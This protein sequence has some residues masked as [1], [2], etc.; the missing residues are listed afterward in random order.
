[1][2]SVNN[3]Y[4]ISLKQSAIEWGR[5][6]RLHTVA[7]S[8]TVGFIGHLTVA[9]MTPESSLLIFSIVSLI[10]MAGCT[11]NDLY[12]LEYDKFDPEKKHRPLVRGSIDPTTAW[13]TSYT[14]ILAALSLMFIVDQH[15]FVFGIFL[16]ATGSY[17]NKNSKDNILSEFA[18]ASWET[19]LVVVGAMIA[20]GFNNITTIFC[21]FIFIQALYQIQEGSLKD[22]KGPENTLIKKLGVK[23]ISNKVV[24]PSGFKTLTYTLKIFQITILWIAIYMQIWNGPETM[25]A[26]T[27]SVLLAVAINSVVYIHSVRVWLVDEFNRDEVIRGF[28]VHELTGAVI[29][30]L[31]LYPSGEGDILYLIIFIPMWVLG[32]NYLIHDGALTPSI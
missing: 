9:P 26:L 14:M 30:M 17:Y 13:I 1:M 27:L 7:A 4:S 31:A 18:F 8:A 20:G 2:T 22:I 5:L 6:V 24:Y 28:T 12:D 10:H 23:E 3:N 15:L 32:V 11:L 25:N 21:I 29:A 16:A 19:G